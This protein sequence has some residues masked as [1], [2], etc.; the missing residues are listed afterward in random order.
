MTPGTLLERLK[1]VAAS[2]DRVAKILHARYAKRRAEAMERAALAGGAS[3]P[4]RLR[5]KGL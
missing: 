5:R 1:A 4:M 3:P 2:S